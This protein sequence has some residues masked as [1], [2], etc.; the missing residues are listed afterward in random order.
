[1]RFLSKFALLAL[2]LGSSSNSIF[3]Q[4]SNP[5]S[6]LIRGGTLIDGTGAKRRQA[7]VR[8]TGD[9]VTAIGKLKPL[10]NEKLIDAKGLV[11]APGFID[12]HSHADGGLLAD[13]EAATQIRQGITT[14]IVGQDGGSH[15]PLK[16]WFAE[17]ERK[18]VALNI[19]SFVGHGT[20]RGMAT[21]ENYK[22]GVTSEEKAKMTALVEQE[23]QSGGLGL[24]TGLEY[25]PGFYSDTEELIACAK[26]AGKH[27][28]IY[29]SHVRDEGNDAIKSFEELIKIA[30]EAHLPAQI[31]HIK[32]DTSPV[33]GKAD[34]V[35]KLIED[36]K[37]R[38]DDI[39]VDV[40]PYLYWQSTI[41]VLIPTRDWDDR[42]AWEKGIAEVGGADHIRLS[43][44]TP[45][46]MWQGKT[47]GEISRLTGKD[48]VT[49]IQEV[50]RKTHGK[51]AEGS[52][53]VVVTAMTDEDLSK[54]IASPG[55][56]FC[57]D[58]GLKGTHP[59]GA[60]TFPR[61]LGEYVRVK[62]VLS[63]ESAIRKM[64]GL[65]AKRMGLSDRGELKVGKKADIVLFDP[66]T[67]LDRATVQTPV[68]PPVGIKTVFVNGVAAFEDGMI[69]GAYPGAVL[70]H[71]L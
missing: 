36:A 18:H 1:M 15:F 64:T 5:P 49:V 40:Y 19:A 28:G 58:G 48:P 63:L 71:K 55:V 67:V 26:V 51:G 56:M 3:A 45:D 68:A 24:S 47:I 60:G 6:I 53:S 22:R 41:I 66:K 20:I 32:L 34:E 37:K 4:T 21:G 10:T 9:T 31:S 43:T 59:R 65:T 14:A 27:G 29:I 23:M 42:G 8:I 44:Y 52:E 39:S 12:A 57:S 16:D 13:P 54:F 69:T 50:V 35:L 38:G 61:I 70:R 46:K 62:K 7:D 11:L 33:W 30:E 17:L 25:D 2:F